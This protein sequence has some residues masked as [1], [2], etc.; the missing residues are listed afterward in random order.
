MKKDNRHVR[1][2]STRH[3]I[4]QRLTAI[5]LIPLSL[6]LITR[7]NYLYGEY[8]TALGWASDP[9]VAALLELTLLILLL[10]AHLGIVVIVEDYV[11]NAWQKFSLR[12]S[13]SGFA[14]LAIAT[15]ISSVTLVA[16]VN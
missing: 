9:I 6:W 4:L 2:S 5:L 11:T 3:W 8:E 10:H 7:S 15:L 13:A 1:R 14:L 12:L 16:T